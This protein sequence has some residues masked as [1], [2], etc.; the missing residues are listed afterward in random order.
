MAANN[1]KAVSYLSSLL[2][3][4]LHIAVPDGRVF[5]GTFKCT[6]CDCNIVLSNAF[7]YS[8]PSAEAEALAKQHSQVTGGGPARANMTSRFLGLIVV[9][10]QQITSIGLE[11]RPKL[12]IDKDAAGNH[13]KTRSRLLFRAFQLSHGFTARRFLNQESSTIPKPPKFGTPQFLSEVDLHLRIDKSYQSPV[14]SFTDHVRYAM[15]IVDA[16]PERSLAVFDVLDIEE[17]LHDRFGKRCKP[18]L[19]PSI[20]KHYDLYDL[21]GGYVGHGELLENVD[22]E[23]KQILARC[24][25]KAFKVPGC[26]DS[27]DGGKWTEFAYALHGINTS[28]SPSPDSLVRPFRDTL[29]VDDYGA[30]GANKADD[31]EPAQSTMEETLA[32]KEQGM[33]LLREAQSAAE[34][35][36][37]APILDGLDDWV[38]VSPTPP[39]LPSCSL[40]AI[41]VPASPSLAPT[42]ERSVIDLT[43]EPA[44][45]DHTAS[46]DSFLEVEM[47]IT[48]TP[49][50]KQ[51]G[52]GPGLEGDD[53]SCLQ[54]EM[55][56]T[57]LPQLG[58]ESDDDD[59]FLVIIRRVRAK[60]QSVIFIGT[61]NHNL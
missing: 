39:I 21:P 61:R 35:G 40:H 34:I 55:E 38:N 52:R 42:R 47:E 19:V 54:V 51:Q 11:E 29:S 46:E 9:P 37:N 44:E 8:Q 12:R 15:R 26:N 31:H 36:T 57:S 23:Y 17:D 7:E 1:T 50:R 20:C 10:K 4:T 25:L 32:L 49:P 3:K 22:N 60:S 33:V 48:S 6:D 27:Y 45:H 56:V 16:D 59:D 58:Q 53:D 5:T 2:G 28:P 14:L 43:A 18:Y 13:C 41:D 30:E 24:L